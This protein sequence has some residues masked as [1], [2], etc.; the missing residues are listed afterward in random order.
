[1]DIETVKNS[2]IIKKR[3]HLFLILNAHLFKSF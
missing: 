1:M 2:F 3:F